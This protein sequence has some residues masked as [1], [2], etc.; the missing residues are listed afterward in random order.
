MLK[1]SQQCS[2]F[3]DEWFEG[4]HAYV[5][6]KNEHFPIYLLRNLINVCSDP[7]NS[8]L[9]SEMID[10]RGHM[11]RFTLKMNVFPSISLEPHKCVLKPW[12]QCSCFWDDRFEG[13]H[14]YVYSKNEC[15]PIYLLR[16]PI[17]VCW[18]PQNSAC[19]SEM[20]NLRCHMPRFTLKMNVFSSISLQTP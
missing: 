7:Q 12:E 18:N 16:N 17:N 19:F 15:F 20:I 10:L 5:Y 11:P 9:F 6:S 4:S 1:P 3:W 14:A 13:S 8:A 2:F